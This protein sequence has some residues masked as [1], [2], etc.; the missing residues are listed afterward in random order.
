[1]ERGRLLVGTAAAALLV[2]GCAV[3]SGT[4]NLANGKQLFSDQCAACHT[5]ARANA[6]GVV[7][8]NLDEAFR[9]SKVDGLGQSTIEGVVHQWILHPNRNVQVDP[10]SESQGK[11]KELTLMPAGIYTGEDARD[12]AAYVAS[13]VA[14]PGKDPGALAN[15]GAQKAQGTAQEKNGTL[16]IPV[17]AGGT[18]YKFAD[19]AASAGT[20]K[21]SSQNPQTTDHNIA[22]EGPGL[23]QKG[24]IVNNNGVS[25]ITVDLKPGTYTFFCSVDGH[26]Q[27]GMQGKLTVK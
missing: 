15:I 5:L 23:S 3:K 19:A 10:K 8:P 7:G 22:I 16:D 20:V 9:Q 18:A 4:A 25:T 11:Y 17:A 14:E 27:A 12:V 1:M 2:S 13:A 6:T 26:R 21:I 24:Q